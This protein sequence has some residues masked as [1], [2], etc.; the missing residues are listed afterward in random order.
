MFENLKK[1]IKANRVGKKKFL[2]SLI[3]P[4]FFNA[5]LWLRF[6]L[7]LERHKLPTFFAYRYLYHIHA[8][9]FAECVKLGGGL[10][11]PHPR[12]LLFCRGAQVGEN[13]VLNGNVRFTLKHGSAPKVGDNCIVGDGVIFLGS[14][15]VADNTIVG[16][17]SVV[18]KKF[19]PNI[20]ICGSPAKI[21]RERS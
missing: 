11:L 17:G 9:E 18:T 10:G 3:V 21:L 4:N 6:Y 13:T 5:I 7:F 16:A 15:V 14:A 12:G 20:V 1:D 8:L 2:V 19:P